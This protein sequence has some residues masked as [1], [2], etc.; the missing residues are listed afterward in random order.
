MNSCGMGVPIVKNNT[1]GGVLRRQ[2]GKGRNDR[3]RKERQDNHSRI[4]AR[5]K[6]GE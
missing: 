2:H 5:Q 4:N 1:T 6:A 3:E